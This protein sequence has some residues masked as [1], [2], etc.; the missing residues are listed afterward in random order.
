LITVKAQQLS[1]QHLAEVA[2]AI[3]NRWNVATFVKM[4][5]IVVM[6]DEFED[7]SSGSIITAPIDL[8]D[9][10]R[11][12]EVIMENLELDGAFKLE[13]D[14]K[15]GFKLRLVDSTRIPKWVERANSNVRRP[16]EGVYECMHCG[17]WLNSELEL[18]L[19]TKLHY[20]I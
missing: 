8:R 20:I 3:Q 13:K 2:L 14:G 10:E 7:E 17:K 12:M 6:D 16:P 15:R 11:G 1:E 9:I 19:H 18:S 5:E 4:H